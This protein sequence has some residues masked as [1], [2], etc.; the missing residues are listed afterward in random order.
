MDSRNMTIDKFQLLVDTVNEKFE[1]SI[2]IIQIS[3]SKFADKESEYL[4]NCITYKDTFSYRETILFGKYAELAVV[5]HGGLSIGLAAVNT[6]VLA[7]YPCIHKKIMTTYDSEKVYEVSKNNHYNCFI[8]KCQ[9][10]KSLLQTFNE[11]EFPKIINDVINLLS[12]L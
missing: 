9:K 2:D 4:N 6:T 11:E 12:T 10:C 1:N 8:E 3:P 5:P 7:I